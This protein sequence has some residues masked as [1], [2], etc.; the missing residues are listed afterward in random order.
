MNVMMSKLCFYMGYTPPFNGQNYGSQKVYGSEITSIKLAESMTDLYTVYMFVNGLDESEEI[1]YNGVHYLNKNRLHTFENIDIM[2]VVR[3]INYFIY[4]KNIANKTFIYLHD[5]TVQPSYNGVI[6]HNNGDQFL[7]NLRDI[8]D[9]LVVLSEYH[10]NNNYNYIG[11]DKSKYTIIPNILDT[12]FYKPHVEKIKNSFIYM[13]DISRGFDIL[14]DCLIYIQKYIPDISLVVFR[15]HEFTDTIKAKIKLLNNTT[16]YGKESQAKIAEECLK[17]EY[18]FYPTNFAETFCNC[19]AEAQLYHCICIYNNI[20]AL[21]TTI[22]NRG[23]QINYSINDIDYVE[24]TC[25]DVMDLMKNKQKKMDYILRGHHWAKHLD[26]KY[27]KN[28]WLDLFK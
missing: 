1:I 12:S 21:N 9:K 4:F 3:Y 24:K 8:Y 10:F 6:L 13:S 15:S 5:V 16:I 7:Y 20:G 27:I 2:I 11:I 23:L 28:M 26:I 19:A 25:N 18:F 14:L 17:A 22:G